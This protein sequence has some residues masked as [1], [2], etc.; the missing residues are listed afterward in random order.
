MVIFHSYVSL[1]EG[2]PHPHP[3]PSPPIPHPPSK[4]PRVHPHSPES[5]SRPTRPR[6][7]DRSL[8]LGLDGSP[9]K[10]HGFRMSRVRG[11]QKNQGRKLGTRSPYISICL[12]FSGL[13][14][15]HA[16]HRLREKFDQSMLEASIWRAT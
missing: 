1:P 8:P 10:N 2:I 4:V 13:I 14:I 3:H 12:A 7:S 9:G 11:P 15:Q 16:H 5:P 6:P